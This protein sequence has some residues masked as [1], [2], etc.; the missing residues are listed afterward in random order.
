MERLDQRKGG[1]NCIMY[2]YKINNSNRKIKLGNRKYAFQLQ[3]IRLNT[4]FR[5]RPICL[6][7]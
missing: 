3:I 5:F 7:K 2:L 6:H 1:R 4:Y